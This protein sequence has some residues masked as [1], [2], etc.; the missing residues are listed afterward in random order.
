LKL[1]L[2]TRRP[3]TLRRRDEVRPAVEVISRANAEAGNNLLK[4]EG[5]QRDR[6]AGPGSQG[7]LLKRPLKYA[8]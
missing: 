3:L 5:P 6:D 1:A 8:G 7:F 2:V 4:A